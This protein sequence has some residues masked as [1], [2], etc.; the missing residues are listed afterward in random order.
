MNRRFEGESFIDA[1]CRY[2]DDGFVPPQFNVWA[3]LSIVAG[4]LE[5]KVWLPWSDTYSYYPNIYVMLVSL[6]GDGKSVALTRAVGLLQ[7][8]NAKTGLLSIMPNQVTEAKFIEL[9]GHGRSFMD[10]RSGREIVHKQN[11]GYY[12]ASEA[13]NAL[14]NIFGDF[15]ACLTDFYD[16]PNTW[17]RATKKDGKKIQLTNVCMNMIAGS[18]FDYL[19]KLV[20]DENIQG[21]FASRL[22]YVVSKNKEVV[23]QRFQ[24]GGV[25]KDDEERREYR[26]A[27]VDD[28]TAI[29]RMVGPMYASPEF[30]AAWE[31]WYPEFERTR[32]QIPSEKLQSL[33]ARANTNI[34]KVAMLLSAADGSDRELK[35][36]HWERAVGLVLPIYETIPGLFRQARANS[37]E[38]SPGNIASS[39]I[40]IIETNP[41]ITFE[42]VYANLARQ[43]YN[44]GLIN[45]VI[46]ALTIDGTLGR[47]GPGGNIAQLLS[48]ANRNL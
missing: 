35:F 2:A 45:Q 37:S 9:M 1:Y 28:L 36:K 6:P 47:T 5:R 44:Q 21:G 29:S 43:G 22:I 25:D 13:S 46:N 41:G 7:A 14:K 11:A 40:H 24:L 42:R 30:A 3:A 38:R 12:W 17:E 39:V 32:R 16:C 31:K 8:V 20:N 4:A 27:L 33:I 26:A 48:D 19:G 10:T 34:L 23:E 15:I 18:T